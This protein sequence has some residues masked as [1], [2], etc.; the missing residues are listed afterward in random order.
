MNPAVGKTAVVSCFFGRD[1]KGVFRCTNFSWV[2]VGYQILGSKPSNVT[3][4]RPTQP[5]KMSTKDYLVGYYYRSTFIFLHICHVL[6][7]LSGQ[8]FA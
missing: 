3:N 2:G 6:F 4:P 7:C 1:N 5:T 8:I